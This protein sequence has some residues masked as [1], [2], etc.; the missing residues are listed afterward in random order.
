MSG[1]HV[2]LVSAVPD[3][4]DALARALREAGHQVSVLADAAQA[5]KALHS[6]THDALVVDLRHPSLDR[7]AMASSLS[8]AVPE[9]APV[10]LDDVERRHIITALLYTRGNK[11]R[12]AQI[13]G[14]ARSTLI[15]KVRRYG[16]ED[17]ATRRPA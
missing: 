6:G 9:A 1:L 5:G 3:R 11:R 2:V 17:I 7:N 14:I 8:P 12:A 10:P 16:L 13:L 4:A 15:Q